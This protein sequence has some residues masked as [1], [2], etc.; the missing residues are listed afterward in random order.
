MGRK[1]LPAPA[2][3]QRALK[4]AVKTFFNVADQDGRQLCAAMALKG[5]LS[6]RSNLY[7]S[8]PGLCQERRNYK[9][10]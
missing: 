2:G 10:A 4:N 5:G 7:K 8:I 6:V 1:V 3:V 9:L